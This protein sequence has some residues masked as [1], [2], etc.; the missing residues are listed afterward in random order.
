VKAAGGHVPDEV[1]EAAV[2]SKNISNSSPKLLSSPQRVSHLI[3]NFDKG[4]KQ[5]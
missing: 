2:A 5:A 1:I 4:R 3:I